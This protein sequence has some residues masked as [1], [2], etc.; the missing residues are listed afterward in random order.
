MS[1]RWS[2][3]AV[4]AAVVT[5]AVVGGVVHAAGA[6]SPEPRRVAARHSAGPL[7]P[8]G[9]TVSART[10]PVSKLVATGPGL[11]VE[12]V[13]LPQ[14]RSI[15]AGA[16]PVADVLR[17]TVQATFEA[18]DAALLVLVDGVPVG[19]AVEAPDLN[20]ATVVVPVNV[21]RNGATVSYG[22]GDNGRSVRVG[23]L[24]VAE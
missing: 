11:R 12:R 6:A 17:L 16:A 7:V 19:R 14:A 22:Y 9:V 20:S 8:V 10:A 24:A 5:A 15:T 2:L 18:R 13:R 21:V 3:L 4:G 23:T 1:L